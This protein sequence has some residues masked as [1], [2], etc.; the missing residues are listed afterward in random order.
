MKIEMKTENK[1]E[2]SREMYEVKKKS[3]KKVE[4]SQNKFGE[5]NSK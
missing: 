4:R 5:E 2:R 1:I 3:K